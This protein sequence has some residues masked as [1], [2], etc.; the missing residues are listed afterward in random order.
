MFLA[1]DRENEAPAPLEMGAGVIGPRS[2][3]VGQ[4]DESTAK[5]VGEGAGPA[6]V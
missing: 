3:N 5:Y 2:G 4:N 1:D 6:T